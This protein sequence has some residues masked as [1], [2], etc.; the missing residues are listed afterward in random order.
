MIW[1][2]AQESL[3]L[4]DMPLARCLIEL[5]NGK[6]WLC[7]AAGEGSWWNP[8]ELTASCG[9]LK[10]EG[11]NPEC[12]GQEHVGVLLSED[13][14]DGDEWQVYWATMRGLGVKVMRTED[15]AHIQDTE[16]LV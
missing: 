15:D 14:S 5:P 11:G 12:P 10:A 3:T 6:A 2:L 8:V 4:T 16:A 1:I 9:H 7:G 13:S